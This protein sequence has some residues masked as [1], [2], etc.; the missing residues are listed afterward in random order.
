MMEGVRACRVCG[1]TDDRACPGGCYWVEPDLCS[2]CAGKAPGPPDGERRARREVEAILGPGAAPGHWMF[3]TSGVLRP[4]VR[5]YLEGAPLTLS[6]FIL[7]R[8]YLRQWIEAPWQGPRITELRAAIDGLN[9]GQ[10]IKRWLD[11]AETE[12]IDPL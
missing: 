6:D 1:C 7:L 5:A 2:Q 9:S 10:A 4:V 11:I 8:D 12:G 3:E